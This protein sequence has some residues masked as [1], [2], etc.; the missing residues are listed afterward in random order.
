M[1]ITEMANPHGVME[2]KGAYNKHASVQGSGI[3]SVTSFLENAVRNTVLE[4][5]DQSLIIADYDSSQ[6][7]L[8]VCFHVC[9]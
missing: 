1:S 5:R 2:S 7:K 4:S 6:G 8:L 3:A 9:C